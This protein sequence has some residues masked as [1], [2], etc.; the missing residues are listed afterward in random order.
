MAVLGRA[1]KLTCLVLIWFTVSDGSLR[2]RAVV[3]VAFF[4]RL[5][6]VTTFLAASG[7]LLLSSFG[8]LSVFSFFDSTLSGFSVGP[9][10][11]C[12]LGDLGA[13]ACVLGAVRGAACCFGAVLG[14]AA[15]LLPD[16]SG[17]AWTLTA[18]ARASEQAVRI[19][20]SVFMMRS[21][22][23]NSFLLIRAP[24][25]QCVCRSRGTAIGLKA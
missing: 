15:G 9:V 3:V 4:R 8:A 12:F 11:S 13:W 1:W 17:F 21:P 16:L 10:R 22:G 7:A 25:S 14:L 24:T 6:S 18:R 5:S 19:A 23:L 20:M 2:E